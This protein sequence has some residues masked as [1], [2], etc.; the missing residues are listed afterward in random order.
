MKH[1]LKQ[2]LP[3]EILLDIGGVGVWSGPLFLYRLDVSGAIA[4][5]LTTYSR[6]LV[7]L[8]Y[9]QEVSFCFTW[10]I[11]FWIKRS[12]WLLD[13]GKVI[14]LLSLGFV[15]FSVYL[16]CQGQEVDKPLG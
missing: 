6:N 1:N 7:L 15:F 12:H 9:S 11:D 10:F 5:Y 13:T 3:L 4:W 14:A 2:N 8:L 16:Q